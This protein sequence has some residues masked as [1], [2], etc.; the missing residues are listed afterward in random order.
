[1]D[2]RNTAK[3]RNASRSNSE[4][5]ARMRAGAAA[6]G[7]VGA[8]RFHR[9]GGRAGAGPAL[10]ASHSHRRPR[11]RVQVNQRLLRTQWTLSLLLAQGLCWGWG[12]PSTGERA[13][14]RKALLLVPP[15]VALVLLL[16][17]V[18]RRG[19]LT[20][21]QVREALYA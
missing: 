21:T 3:T 18:R 20:L 8:S 2:P 9:R 7:S 12:T 1:M 16:T 6:C 17:R 4:S 15:R 19:Y 11:S 13:T 5:A 10:T 14:Q